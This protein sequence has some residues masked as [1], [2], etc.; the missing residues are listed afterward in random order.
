M[1]KKSITEIKE[2]AKTLQCDYC[3]SNMEATGE[4]FTSLNPQYFVTCTHCKKE[5]GLI[6]EY[7]KQLKYTK[8]QRN[9]VGN[10]N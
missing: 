4:Y 9:T 3:K 8:V 1:T 5:F 7:N 6:A 10:Y 2:F